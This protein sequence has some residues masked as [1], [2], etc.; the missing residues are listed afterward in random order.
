MLADDLEKTRPELEVDRLVAV[1]EYRHTVSLLWEKMINLEKKVDE[2]P[3]GG[4][5]KETPDTML[6]RERCRTIAKALYYATA[7]N[8]P[9]QLGLDFGSGTTG[10]PYRTIEDLSRTRTRGFTDRLVSQLLTGEHVP[11]YAKEDIKVQGKPTERKIRELESKVHFL[12]NQLQNDKPHLQIYRLGAGSFL[13]AALSLLLW[14]FFG[15]AAP[16]HPIFAVL[17]IP[18]ALGVMAMAFLIRRDE[19]PQEK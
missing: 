3:W 1:G 15:I 12:E 4:P 11:P 19:S 8:R 2:I 13:V 6:E 17:V 5:N 18:A 14:M 9:F 10:W 7:R 16:F